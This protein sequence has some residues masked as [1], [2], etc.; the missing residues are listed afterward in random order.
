MVS[1]RTRWVQLIGGLL[2]LLY[3]FVLTAEADQYTAPVYHYCFKAAPAE[4]W[5]SIMTVVGA[6]TVATS[7]LPPGHGRHVRHAGALLSGSAV[8]V[9]IIWA[10]LLFAATLD[11][12]LHAGTVAGPLSWVAAAAMHLSSVVRFGVER[13]EP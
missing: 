3:G 4:V 8:F 6:V 12:N 7:V 13:T 1:M 9:M 2:L 11:P 5:G 10:G